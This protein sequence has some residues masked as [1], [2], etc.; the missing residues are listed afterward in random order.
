M[1][2]Q[3]CVEMKCRNGHVSNSSSTSFLVTNVSDKTVTV[4]DFVKENASLVDRFNSWYDYDY[5][6]DQLIDNAVQLI[7]QDP[8]TYMILPGV[9][10]EWVFGDEDGTPIGCVYDYM[11]RDGGESKSFKWKFKE[12]YR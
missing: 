10:I 12:Y 6:N 7:A 9:S 1:L 2:E 5:N 4:E 11:L 8:E 3:G